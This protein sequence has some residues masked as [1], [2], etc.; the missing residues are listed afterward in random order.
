MYNMCTVAYPTVPYVSTLEL[1][2][3][4]IH[5]QFHLYIFIF[6]IFV[7][8]LMPSQYRGAQRYIVYMGGAFYGQG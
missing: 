3:S 7:M 6:L 1:L 4:N 8:D 2:V 5:F